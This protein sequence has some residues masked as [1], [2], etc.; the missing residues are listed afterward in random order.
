[1]KLGDFLSK[2]FDAYD[3]DTKTYHTIRDAGLFANLCWMIRKVSLMELHGYKVENINFILHEY[4]PKTSAYDFLFEKNNLSI[5]LFNLSDED[6]LNFYQN[7]DYSPYGLGN[8][9]RDINL[10]ITNP[11]I[12]KFFTPNQEVFGWYDRFVNQIGGDIKNV[13]FIWARRTDKV[14]ESKMPEVKSYLKILDE[15]GTTN[16]KI[17]IQTDDISVLNEFENSGIEFYKLSDIPFSTK[18]RK[19][20]H[21]NLNDTSNE[22][23]IRTYGITKVD[24]LRQMLALSLIAKNAYKTILYPGNP[25]TY[26]PLIKGSFEDCFLFRDDVN[27]F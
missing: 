26:I 23:F 5:D 25:S 1:M 16:K 20:F 22:E 9:L 19:P 7:T 14:S 3:V 2:R 27:L 12:S 6:K 24:Y 17:L 21:L 11:I 10:K 8:N 15:I 13:I 4:I 18:P